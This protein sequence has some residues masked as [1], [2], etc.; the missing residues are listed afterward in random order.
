MNYELLKKEDN[1]VT[2]SISVDVDGFKVAV[3]EAY[4]KERKHF[5]MSGF[6]KGKA[7]KKVIETQYGEGVFYEEA[8]NIVLNQHYPTVVEELKLDVV[9][10]PDV[11][12]KEINPEVGIV[13]EAT[14]EVKPE[15]TVENYKGIE[16]EKIENI[17]TD[18]QLNE[19]IA[20]VQDQN[21]RIVNLEEGVVQNLDKVDIN[22]KGFLGEE[23]FDGGTA[24]GHVLEIGSG[25][26]IPGFEEQLIDAKIGTEVEVNVSFPEDYQAENLAGK[27]VV[28]KVDI[29]SI[30]RKE[31]PELDDEFAQD[32]SEFDTLEEYKADLKKVMIEQAANAD[33]SA[34]RDKVIEAVADLVDFDIPQGMI[35]TEVDSMMKEFG[36]Q[37]QHQGLELD[38]YYEITGSSEKD[39]KGQM[40][41]DAK[42]RVK[43]NLVIENI[44]GLEK[45]EASEDD[46]NEELQ[47][48]AD[49]Q[50]MELD[51]IKKMFEA[52]NFEY[53]K[54][55]IATRKT[56]DFLVDNVNYK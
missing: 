5:N 33:K 14:V 26:F 10:R 38:K 55:T 19:E 44:K 3:K 45:I 34:L 11:D 46:L 56:V 13:I 29:N 21:A 25:Q 27:A 31:L 32:I 48:Y 18:D 50:K 12:V 39:L 9:D 41:E 7:P 2:I 4:L 30:S 36:M 24:D 40:S 47:K 17:V 35:N 8:I 37:L 6:R 43:T 16:V 42:M 22:Y 23:Q 53:I 54:N 20:K 52:D 15:I 28:F 1:K 49:A 51:K